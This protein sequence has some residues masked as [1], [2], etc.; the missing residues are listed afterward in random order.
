ME[1][2]YILG[3]RRKK[4][5]GCK[6]STSGAD[7]L[8]DLQT[9]HMYGDVNAP[10]L[11]YFIILNIESLRS[12]NGKKYTLT[13]EI[14]SLINLREINMIALDEI[15]KNI[16]PKSVQGKLILDIKKKTGTNAEWIPM[17]GTPIVNK[18]TDVFT[19]LKLV[20]GHSV[21]SFWE[22]QNL[23]CVMGGFGGHEIVGYKNIPLLKN[24]LQSNMLRRLKTDVLDLPPKIHYTEYVENTAIQQELY[25]KV[26]FEL[27][28]R[29]D[30]IISSLNPLSKM[31]K[32]RQCNGSPELIDTTIKI[33]SSDY[34]NKNAKLA[35]LMELVDDIVERNEKVVIFSN[36]V[37][38][39]KPV[40]VHLSTRHKVAC[41]TGSMSESNRQK[42]KRVFINNP[43]YKILIGTIGALGTNHTL[44]VANNVIFYDE[45]WVASDKIQGEDRC[46]RATSTTP[47]NI[48]TLITKGTIDEAVHKI[49]YDKKGISDYIVDDRLELKD[50]PELFNLLLG[51]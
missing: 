29:K 37:Q 17:T 44:T 7:K 11:P 32:L 31:L 34:P 45:P 3:T 15:H 51:K 5:G 1:F 21:K 4:H 2:A 35:R 10:E 40:Y 50:N 14:I 9:G 12:K 26:Q 46:H 18:P 47:V 43:E 39:L 27:I 38:H 16:S 8:K 49:L 48:Y 25:N 41:Y 22:W 19:P 42:H 36:W 20:G 28:S 13:D 6:Y 23:F 30:E 33:K 24:M